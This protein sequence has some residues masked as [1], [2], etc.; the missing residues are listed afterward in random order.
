M[1]LTIKGRLLL[2][3]LIATVAIGA[4][5]GIAI[6]GMRA[7]AD[8]QDEGNHRAEDGMAAI[9]AA[10][11]GAS[12]YQVVADA[13]INRDLEASRKDWAAIK[14]D[15]QAKMA[16]VMAI[17]DT[18]EEKQ[19][20]ESA[21][22]A[23]RDFIDVY[24]QQTLPLLANDD[25]E[26]MA[27][28]REVD[29]KLDQLAATVRDELVKIER[30]LRGEARA[31]DEAFDR[32]GRDTIRD[33]L[34]V[35][36][37]LLLAMIALSIWI[38]AGIVRPLNQAVAAAGRLAEGDLTTRLEYTAR[39]EIGDLMDALRH[40][41]EKLSHVIGEVQGTTNNLASASEQIS[42]TAQ[43]L[44]QSSSEQAASVEQTSAS[45][46]Q[47]TASIG[48]NSQSARITDGMASQ[49]AKEATEGGAAVRETVDAMKQIAQRI[50]IVD[51]IAYQTNLLAL[52]AAIEAARAGE[53][54]KGFAVVASE[55]RKLAE[56]SQVAAREIGELAAGSVGAA[57]RAGA[58][59][60][61]IVP[62][63][64][65]TSGLVR[66]IAAASEEQSTGVG[67]INAAMGQ[68]NQITQ[69]NAS[70]SEQLAATAEEMGSQAEMLSRLM[71]FF[72]TQNRA[73]G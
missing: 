39:D 27:R 56:R 41:V 13:I 2:N 47:M 70:A 5:I 62:S 51:D 61:V 26:T 36:A 37:V 49:A 34:I 7:L 33:S 24:E 23:M 18:G 59:L 38:V 52:N 73:T 32:T 67:Q 16:K 30:S 3:M 8:L 44:S 71:Q 63:I 10:Y 45:V 72:R 57:E 48:Q 21:Q 4:L 12:L 58:L 53:Q 40:M 28:I 42:A 43:S 20:A 69:Q 46:E 65:K 35:G 9:D 14:Q 54:G 64:G 19:W 55:V 6:L 60:D 1:N 25:A 17:V 15:S 11:V 31:A 66:E 68:L 22:R 29:D 50:G